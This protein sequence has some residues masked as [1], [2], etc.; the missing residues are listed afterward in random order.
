MRQTI[1]GLDIGVTSVKGVRIT[2][3]FR[4]M[5]LLDVF[6]APV[7]MSD[8]DTPEHHPLQQAQIA[9]LSELVASE[10]IKKGDLIALALSGDFISIRE[11]TLPFTDLKKIEQV[12]PYEVESE[13][14]FDLEEVT[15]DYTL[16]QS[17]RNRGSSGDTEGYNTS[18]KESHLLISAIQNDLIKSYLQSLQDIDIDPAWIG[19][20]PLSLVAYARYFLGLK[21][22][23]ETETLV[24]DVGASRTVLCHLR[25]QNINWVRTIPLGSDHITQSLVEFTGLT[26]EAAEERKTEIDLYMDDPSDEQEIIELE[27]LEKGVSALTLEIEKSIRIFSPENKQNTSENLDDNAQVLIRRCFH[28]CGGGRRI[29][30]FEHQL[31]NNLEMEIIGIDLAKGGLAAGISGMDRVSADDIAPVYA[32]AFGLAL[33]NTDGPPI[34]FRRGEFVFGKETIARRHRFVSL[35]LIV[36]FLLGLMGVDLTL[37]Y[38]KKENRYLQLKN[39]VRVAFT[40]IF[41]N[42]RNVVNEVAQM[43]T[44]ISERQKTGVFLGV[45]EVSPLQVLKAITE[46]IPETIKIDVFN[47]VIDGGSVRIQAQTNSFESVDRIRSSLLAAEQFKQVE[48][49]DAKV[50]AN[51]AHVRFRLKMVVQEPKE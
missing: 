1:L 35:G 13:L 31:A 48:M 8:T 3:N 39:E 32:Q 43:R 23:V 19:V 28:L 12:A 38:Q 16:L 42:V 41:P 45:N 11:L 15:I 6:E 37:H 50:A 14:P 49:S 5:R 24:I 46:A 25:G 36:F 2:R 47:L 29:K 33:Q 4:G 51:K 26:W 27:A 22:T 17:R 18:K 9:T 44:A 20:N 40:E 10:Q 21:K 30:G 34:N 7:M